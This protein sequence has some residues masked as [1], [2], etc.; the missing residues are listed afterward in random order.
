MLQI[1]DR[2]V[3]A[4]DLISTE[5]IVDC[6]RDSGKRCMYGASST[7]KEFIFG[8]DANTLGNIDTLVLETSKR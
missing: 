5:V 2:S 8:S 7:A 4:A 6:A 3:T 1:T